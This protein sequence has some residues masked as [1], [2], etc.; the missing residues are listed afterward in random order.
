MH[1]TYLTPAYLRAV[2]TQI[3]FHPYT[4][5][6]LEPL[7]NLHAQH[8]IVTASYGALT[9][10]LRHPSGGGPLVPILERIASRLTSALKKPVEPTTVLLLWTRAQGA[11]VVTATKNSEI[12]KKLGEIAALP[13]DLLEQSEI[14]E[15]T[16]VGKTIHF[17]HY[18]REQMEQNF[19]IPDLPSS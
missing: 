1:F 18:G 6:H 8:G 16:P 4:I 17:R 5:A 12:I 3:E 9:P 13:D 7:L 2:S 15:I 19:A 10:L 11:V 14:D